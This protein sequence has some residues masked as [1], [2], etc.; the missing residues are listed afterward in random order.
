M[1]VCMYVCDIISSSVFSFTEFKK[2]FRDKVTLLSYDV[3]PYV[4]SPS[5]N[6]HFTYILV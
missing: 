2:Y 3:D 4:N 5:D 1:Y 6:K